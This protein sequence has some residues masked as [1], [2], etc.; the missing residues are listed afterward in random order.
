M[1]QARGLDLQAALVGP[2]MLGEDLEDDLCA[3]EH[4]NLELELEV[5]LLSRAEV[6]VADDQIECALE[7]EVAELIQLAHADEVG[8]VDP[9]APLD[10]GTDD[11][12]AGRPGE[13]GQLGHLL[14]NQLRGGSR[15]HQPDQVCPLAR[16]PRDQSL[17]RLSRAIASSRRASE[18][19]TESRK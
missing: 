16:R 10:V 11:I 15:Q 13:V 19:V 1:V 12:G 5:A 14:V 2:C 4:A 9:G 7:L 8:R 6:V 3:V 18:A 17:S